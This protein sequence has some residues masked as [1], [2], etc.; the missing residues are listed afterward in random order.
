MKHDKK[1]S[2][3]EITIVKVEKVGEFVLKTEPFTE[4]AKEVELL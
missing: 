4:F 3:K 2:G 1:M